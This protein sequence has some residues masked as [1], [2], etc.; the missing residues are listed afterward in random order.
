MRG[1]SFGRLFRLTTFG[2]SHGAAIGG[3]LDGCPAGLKLDL[4]GVQRELDRRRPGSTPLGTSRTES[5][6]LEVLSGL[7]EGSTLG[8]PIGFL[9]RNADARSGDYDALKD[10]H[11]PGHADRTWMDKFGLRDHRGGGRSS[12]RTTAACVVGGAIAR[13]LMEPMGVSVSAYVSRV[14]DVSLDRTPDREALRGVWEDA[15][16]CP[17]QGTSARMKEL[18]QQ[19][20]A[21]GDS[22]GGIVS[23]AITGIPAGVGEPVFDK[24]EADLAKAMLSINASKGFQI[25]SGFRAATMRGSEH[26]TLPQ[27]GVLGGISDGQEITF[28]VA[29]KPTATIAR[30]QQA[31]N[32]AD[33]QVVLEVSG[34]HDPCV[35]PR[36]VPIVEAMACMVLMDHILR[37]R[38]ARQ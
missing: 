10:V 30:P 2:E 37:Q 20:R 36:A 22:I 34:R 15:V 5:D 8:T 32:A 3:V 16:R 1:N 31:R 17:D 21:E 27:G 6:R 25:G 12:A 4:S 23:C 29:F 11:R 19:V 24:L 38:S 35:V 26:N 28:E 13:Q 14:G 33:E 7:F 9:I 18:I